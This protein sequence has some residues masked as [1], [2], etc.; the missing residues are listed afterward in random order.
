MSVSLR[1]S[2][3]QVVGH[4]PRGLDAL[5]GEGD[6]RGLDRADPDGQ[7]AL[8][9]DLLQEHDRLVRRKLDP[10]ADER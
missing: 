6:G 10:H 2:R 8:S 4:G 9:V 1:M 7:V 3:K 5:E